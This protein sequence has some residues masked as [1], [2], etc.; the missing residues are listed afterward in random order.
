MIQ[1]AHLPCHY[2]IPQQYHFGASFLCFVAALT[3]HNDN[4]DIRTLE[5]IH[6]FLISTHSFILFVNQK[7]KKFFSFLFYFLFFRSLS[8]FINFLFYL[9]AHFKY[10]VTALVL[11]DPTQ[12]DRGSPLTINVL[13]FW[14]LLNCV[15][16][17]S[18]NCGLH[19]VIQ[20]RTL[21][22]FGCTRREH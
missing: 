8:S 7:I 5:L 12:W 20:F 3:I 10:T 2:S 21:S 11:N 13:S 15:W 22:N 1:N 18:R 4:D 14:I 16:S 9:I 6:Q 19:F 17:H